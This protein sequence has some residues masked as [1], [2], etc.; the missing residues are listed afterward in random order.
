MPRSLLGNFLEFFDILK[1][2]S[3]FLLSSCSYRLIRFILQ[4]SLWAITCQHSVETLSAPRQKRGRGMPALASMA[5]SIFLS[6]SSSMAFFLYSQKRCTQ[7]CQGHH[8]DLE[9]WIP[10]CFC[11]CLTQRW[12]WETALVSPPHLPPR[13]LWGN[14]TTLLLRSTLNAHGLGL[15][16]WFLC[17][18]LLSI[19]FP[20]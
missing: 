6:L 10:S 7:F 19:P 18:Q 11:I 4:S 13:S 5:L 14:T 15:Q 3:C 8:P 17:Y 12:L 20:P 16:Q 9:L 2:P 1:I